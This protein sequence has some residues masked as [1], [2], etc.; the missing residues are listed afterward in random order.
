MR[1]K[2]LI[3][4]VVFL[5]ILFLIGN[6]AAAILEKPVREKWPASGFSYLYDNKNYYDV[7]F[8]GTSMTIT[9]ISIEQLYTDYGIA[10]VTLGEPLQNSFLGYYSLEEALKYQSPEVV[11]FDIG[12]FFYSEEDVLENLENEHYYIHYTLDTMKNSKTK[13]EAFQQAKELK[14]D[15]DFWN[16]F[17][18]FYYNHANWESLTKENFAPS[19]NVKVMFG[20]N[21]LFD[22]YEGYAEEGPTTIQNLEQTEEVFELWETNKKYLL[23]LIELCEE[24]GTQL[25]L[26]RGG[27]SFPWTWEKY[28]AI[29]EVASESGVP[30]L[31]MAFYEDEMGLD[32]RCDMADT[33]HFNVNGTRKWTDVVG[34]YLT[35]H[36]ALE[37][38]RADERYDEYQEEEERYQDILDA[39]QAKHDLLQALDFESYL[40]VLLKLDREENTI[41][42]A[43][44]REGAK[45]LS[46]SAFEKLRQLGLVANLTENYSYLGVVDSDGIREAC[47]SVQTTA[48]GILDNQ[49]SFYICSGGKDGYKNTSVQIDGK[50]YVQGGK[51][52]NIVVYN[53]KADE[54]LSSVYFD[55]SKYENSSVYRIVKGKVQYEA[56]VNLWME[57]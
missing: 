19:E 5:L 52:I 40:D 56:D 13:Y 28:N 31:D 16:Y 42:L 55:T 37:D 18:R 20:N 2:K 22:V 53:K 49:K 7:I 23:K 30:F 34:K 3:K 11:L 32:Y 46:D 15:L 14:P 47:E 50:E 45:M 12:S 25:V 9:N 6:T 1:I 43:V 29:N 57:P 17:S 54:V 44:R 4:P 24:K 39:M 26:Y 36:Y 38:R 27:G 10:A 48:E 41:F 35:E 8:C 51:G 21:M 33:K